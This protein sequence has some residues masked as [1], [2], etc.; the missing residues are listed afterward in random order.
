MNTE[1]SL[2]REE[3][4]G[5]IPNALLSFVHDECL[6]A[7]APE[8]FM[9]WSPSPLHPRSEDRW[10]PFAYVWDFGARVVVP[11]HWLAWL[12]EIYKK[13]S[14]RPLNPIGVHRPATLVWK[15]VIELGERKTLV[16]QPEHPFRGERLVV[17]L[18]APFVRLWG[19]SVGHQQQLNPRKDDDGHDVPWL[20]TCFQDWDIPVNLRFDTCMPKQNVSLDIE[21]NVDER[22]GWH[23]PKKAKSCEVRVELLGTELVP[24]E[25][26]KKNT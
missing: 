12:Q 18:G 19:L 15:D 17:T 1:D 6:W 7:F 25:D 8:K 21:V 5:S 3:C 22:S 14:T 26:A 16:V 20:G 10:K 2:S 13:K 24:P 23:V 9:R 11:E 4:L